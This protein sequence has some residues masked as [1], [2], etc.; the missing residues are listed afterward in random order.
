M[1]THHMHCILLSQF[2]FMPYACKRGDGI[3]ND[4]K[5]GDQLKYLKGL[6]NSEVEYRLLSAE[7]AQGTKS[8]NGEFRIAKCSVAD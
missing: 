1:M 5:E 3:G 4:S 2:L 6:M 7:K 8:T